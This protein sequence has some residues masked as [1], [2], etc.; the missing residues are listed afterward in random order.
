MNNKKRGVLTIEATMLVL[1]ILTVSMLLLSFIRNIEMHGRLYNN[2]ESAG[3]V[4]STKAYYV[5]RL[6]TSKGIMPESEKLGK[7]LLPQKIN[8][9][10]LKIILEESLKNTINI[11][12]DTEMLNY[13][14]LGKAIDYEIS[15]GKNTLFIKTTATFNQIDIM[16]IM[17]AFS[18]SDVHI[19][20]L[21]DAQS[22]IDFSQSKARR[23]EIYITDHGKKKT[24][25]YHTHSCFGLK[26]AKT[27]QK[28]EIPAYKL[29]DT[30]EIE[31]KTFTLCPFCKKD[32]A[33]R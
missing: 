32:I 7:P 30:I 2:M 18:L 15:C 28:H 4:V 29:Y 27:T 10:W 1:V 11:Q 16:G 22:I 20:P 14:H 33:S 24:H 31:G 6:L 8:E 23:A 3:Q 19:I 26:R 13:Y 12:T 17:P 21:K 9:T 25:V 5:N